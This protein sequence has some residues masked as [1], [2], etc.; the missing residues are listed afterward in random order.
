MANKKGKKQI[1]Q[2]EHSKKK[3]TNIPHVG[4]VT[5][6]S[7]PDTGEKKTYEYLPS[8]IDID[9][10]DDDIITLDMGIEDAYETENFISEAIWNFSYR[11]NSINRN[12][13][14]YKDIN[15]SYLQDLKKEKIRLQNGDFGAEHLDYFDETHQVDMDYFPS[16]LRGY[17]VSI[18]L[19]SLENML[20]E[21]AEEVANDLGKEIKL[22]TRKLPFINKYILWF[23]RECNIDF[24]IPKKINKSLDAIRE[25]RNRFLH[26]INRDIP[27]NIIKTINEMTEEIKSIENV[28]DD[29]F[30][31]KSIEKIC[32][33][34][35]KIENSLIAFRIE[36]NN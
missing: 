26:K 3:R 12:W 14:I 5:P 20:A 24:S 8:D 4:L 7:D 11:I 21:L 17:I 25:I 13:I 23:A 1:E 33:L 30:V 32:I 35:K 31:D 22:D 34:V 9:M 19:S 27:D 2:Y 18:A 28:V 29:N 10:L 16:N 6:E 15:Y 36:K